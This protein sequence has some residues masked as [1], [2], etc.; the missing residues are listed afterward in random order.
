M[1]FT[2]APAPLLP[3]PI[4]FTPSSR[5]NSGWLAAGVAALAVG[6]VGWLAV[7]DA[8]G[9]GSTNIAAPV[10]TASSAGSASISREE[11]SATYFATFGVTGLAPTLDCVATQMGGA[12]SQ[13]ERLAHG[14]L[15]TFAEATAA[16]TPFVSCA[17]DVDFLAMM[18]PSAVE[19]FGGDVDEACVTQRF[20]TFGGQGRAE[21]RALA[22]VD[23]AGFASSLQATFADCA[24]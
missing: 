5:R 16:F 8:G 15:L 23:L 12:G 6:V 7:R 22:L 21:A 17:P 9:N 14:E 19:A 20:L 1:S 4:T 3:T 24:F 13:A 2:P 11:L 10:V 18:V